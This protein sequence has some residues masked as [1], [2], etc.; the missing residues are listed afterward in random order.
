M[1]LFGHSTRFIL[2][3][4]L[5]T[6]AS[7]PHNV[8]KSVIRFQHFSNAIAMTI[9]LTGF[10]DQTKCDA[11]HQEFHFSGDIWF[12]FRTMFDREF[13][14]FQSSSWARA[15]Q[16]HSVNCAASHFN[17]FF[18]QLLCIL[19]DF[20]RRSL[21]IVWLSLELMRGLWNLEPV[22]LSGLPLPPGGYHE[23]FTLFQFKCVEYK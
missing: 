19:V 5:A 23:S 9:R 2:L 20:L 6:P 11:M 1:S 12:L 18:Y 14:S 7:I 21:R 16:R 22:H 8:R 4:Y 17:P 15:A 13:D 3:H 10:F